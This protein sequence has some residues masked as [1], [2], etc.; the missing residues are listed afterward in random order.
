MAQRL[1]EGI[2]HLPGVRVMHPPQAN[3]VFTF[4]PKPV[5]A[6]MQQAKGWRFYDFIAGG[7]CR[8]MCAWDT[9]PETVDAFIGDLA[10]ACTAH[11]A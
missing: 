8:L 1:Y 9:Q 7:G 4:L 5:I 3:A 6:Q 11:A 10:E 2:H